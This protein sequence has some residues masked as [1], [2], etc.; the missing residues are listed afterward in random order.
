MADLFQD[1]G[2]EFSKYA[3]IQS[4]L[5]YGEF[6]EEKPK[7]TIAIPTFKRPQLLENAIKS[8]L[9]QTE[10]NYEIIIIDNDADIRNTE[11]ETLVKSYHNPRVLYYKNKKNI[12][13]FGNWNRCIELARSEWVTILNDDDWLEPNYLSEIEEFLERQKDADV[14]IVQSNI[15]DFRARDDSSCL[16][17]IKL[18]FSQISHSKKI[19]WFDYFLR[20][21]S[22][23]SLGVLFKKQ[24]ALQCG[25]FHEKYYPTSDVYFFMELTMRGQC[26]LLPQILANYRIQANES[27]QVAKEFSERGLRRRSYLLRRNYRMRGWKYCFLKLLLAGL[28]ERDRIFIQKFW[29]VELLPARIRLSSFGWK[30]KVA[31]LYLWSRML[32]R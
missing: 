32:L 4:T 22:M 6:G 23:G 24:L 1:E 30:G 7:Y 13:M 19:C 9:F 11:I 31:K 5:I 27:L 8:A 17:Y 21:Q 29:S 3:G 12:G 28:Y 15:H 26:Y 20:N 2:N 10:K 16:K 25:G 18:K 14:I